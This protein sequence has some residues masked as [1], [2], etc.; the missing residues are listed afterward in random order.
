MNQAREYEREH[1]EAGRD[2]Y[3]DGDRNV[4]ESIGEDGRANGCGKAVGFITCDL[5]G[6]KKPGRTRQ[7]PASHTFQTVLVA[8]C[9][10]LSRRG[11]YT[12]PMRNGCRLAVDPAALVIARRA[13]RVRRPRS[14]ASSARMYVSVARRQGLA[15]SRSRSIRLHRAR[16]QRRPGGPPVAPAADPMQIALLVDTSQAATGF[17][18]RLP[19]GASRLHRRRDRGEAGAKNHLSIVGI[20]ERPTILTDYTIEPGRPQQRRQRSFAIKARDLSAR[21]HHRSQPGLKNAR[22]SAR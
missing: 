1:R 4:D 17:I 8:D 14:G 21:R 6:V 19:A 15:G 3:E 2:D 18:A 22:P 12:H 5:R 13:R 16:G 9:L 11:T 10:T 7:F 20:G